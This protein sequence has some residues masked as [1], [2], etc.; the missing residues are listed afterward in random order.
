[1]SGRR[2]RELNGAIEQRDALLR[3]IGEAA[4]DGHAGLPEG[5][6]ALQAQA[7][8]EKAEKEAGDPAAASVRAKA[9]QKA[10]DA[11]A[12]R[13]FG[14]LAQRVLDEGLPLSGQESAIAELRAIEAKIKELS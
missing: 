8:L 4:L 13:A 7:A 10:A 9:A 11:K 2:A 12:K 14:K 5:T 6:A 3:T 1:V